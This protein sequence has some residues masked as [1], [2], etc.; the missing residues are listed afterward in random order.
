MLRKWR[1][2]QNK[3]PREPSPCHVSVMQIVK[4][5]LRVFTEIVF[6]GLCTLLLIIFALERL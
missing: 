1:C 6:Y 2:L 5:E 4:S 3:N